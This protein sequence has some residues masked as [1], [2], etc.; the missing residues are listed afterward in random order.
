MRKFRKTKGSDLAD[1][2]KKGWELATDRFEKLSNQYKLFG[3]VNQVL[4]NP[5]YFRTTNQKG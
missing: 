2:Y 5:I 1:S 3:S 4:P